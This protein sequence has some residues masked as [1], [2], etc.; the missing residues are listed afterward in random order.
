MRRLIF[1]FIAFL[2]V[3]LTSF[4]QSYAFKV[5]VSKGKN[6]FKSSAGWQQLKVGTSLTEK[7][8]IKVAGNS[9][10]GLVHQTGK[11][12]ELKDA[13]TYQVAD[14][15]K[16]ISSGSSVVTKYTDFILSSE[17]KGSTIGATGAVDRG[18]DAIALFLP[19]I[20][21]LSVFYN[22][23]QTISWETKDLKGPF[24]VEFKSLFE[25]ELKTIETSDLNL[26]IDLDGPEFENEDNITVQIKLKADKNKQSK[27]IIVKRLSKQDKVRVQGLLKDAAST[28]EETALSKYILAAFFE[29]NKLLIDAASQYAEAVKLAPDVTTY[30]E[31]FEQFLLRT[32]IKSPPVK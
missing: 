3:Q 27:K 13:K 17:K 16:H 30:Q 28:T 23:K 7:D 14:L 18:G 29:D 20:S 10:V 6:E 12:I 32:N 9:Y 19:T 5:L 1:F 26:T 11:P 21:E 31:S 2:C 25:D 4:G 24:I 22:S 8:E 15:V